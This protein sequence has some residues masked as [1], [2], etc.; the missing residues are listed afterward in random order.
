MQIYNLTIKKFLSHLPLRCR[1]QY[2]S[3][4]FFKIWIFFLLKVNMPY[5][6]LKDTWTIKEEYRNI[7][8]QFGIAP[9][10]QHPRSG[11]E[12]KYIKKHSSNI[13]KINNSIILKSTKSNYMNDYYQY[14]ISVLKYIIDKNNLSINII[15]DRGKY[16][17]NNNNKTIKI[18]INYE[19]TLVKEQPADGDK[20]DRPFGKI[21]YN[22]NKNYLVRIYRFHHL[23]S[24]DIIIDYSNPNIGNVKQS[25][26]FTDFSN[27]HIYVAPILYKN[28]HINTNNRNHQSIT[29]F[30]NINKPRRKKLLKDIGKSTLNHSNINN[31][32]DK[33]KLQELLQ[34]TKVLINI[35]QTPYHNTFEELRCLPALR[36]GVIVVSEKS[37]LNHLIPYND[38][39]IWTDYDNIIDKTKEVLENYEEYYKNIFTNKNID[40][41]NKMDDKNKKVM[42]DKIVSFF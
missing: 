5:K 39:I 36:N 22:E 20:K 3:K 21:K 42:E 9:S 29:T 38:L 18:G 28:L 34:N 13:I 41:L 10:A 14:I 24:S 23:N 4:F 30:I 31:C 27:K 37:P 2:K 26:L 35:H 33:Y 12:E 16:N 19:H 6:K 7:T 8:G 11:L 17:F 15:L 25:R 32:F 1:A 40:I